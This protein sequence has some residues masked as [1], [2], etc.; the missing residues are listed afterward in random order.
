[1][2]SMIQVNSAFVLQMAHLSFT[3]VVF[4]SEC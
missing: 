2:M 3:Q 1:M 4:Q